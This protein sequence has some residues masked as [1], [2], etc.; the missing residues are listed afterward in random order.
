[1]RGIEREKGS[2]GKEKEGAGMGN[3]DNVG[4][5]VKHGP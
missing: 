3:T 1:V 5:K 4:S 2:K